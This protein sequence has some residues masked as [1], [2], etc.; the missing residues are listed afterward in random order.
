MSFATGGS[1]FVA[2][3]FISSGDQK[4]EYSG[5]VFG[6]GDVDDVEILDG[7]ATLFMSSTS[8]FQK[9]DRSETDFMRGVTGEEMTFMGGAIQR[10]I[11]CCIGVSCDG[12]DIVVIFFAEKAF[13]VTTF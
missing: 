5:S 13:S 7:E 11:T 12:T 8:E 2:S 4:K 1:F 3:S 10:D 9:K 6:S